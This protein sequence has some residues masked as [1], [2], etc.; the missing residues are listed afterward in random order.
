VQLIRS[1]LSYSTQPREVITPSRQSKNTNREK[2][3]EVKE[4]ECFELKK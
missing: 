3:K 2:I 4:N 1:D